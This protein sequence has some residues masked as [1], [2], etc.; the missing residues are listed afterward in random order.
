MNIEEIKG[1]WKSK[2][3]P[4][5]QY[6]DEIVF[7]VYVSESH[8]LTLWC[9]ENNKKPITLCQGK[10]E[11]IDEENDEFQLEIDGVAKENDFLNLNCRMH[12]KGKPNAFVINIPNYNERYMEKLE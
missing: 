4:M 12:L 6:E 10:L 5:F 9:Q 1:T 2:E 11:I 7:T 8:I 3:T